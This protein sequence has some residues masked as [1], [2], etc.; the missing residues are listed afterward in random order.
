[1]RTKEEEWLLREKYFGVVSDAYLADVERL[2]NGEP[3]D[4]VIGFSLFL[5]SQ[6]D[7]SERTLIPRT[8]TEYWVEKAI[9]DIRTRFPEQESSKEPIRCLDVFSGSGCIGIAVLSHIK[10]TTMD[11]ADI[12]PRAITQIQRNI[13]QNKIDP[14]RTLVYQSDI[15][16]N[17]PKGQKYD[18][19]FA[20]PPYIA[21]KD[22]DRVDD[23]VHDFEPHTALYSA[24]NGFDHIVR[25]LDSVPQFLAPNGVVFLEFDD[26]QK[27]RLEQ[28]LLERGII[29]SMFHKD[30]FGFWRW[31]EWKY[32]L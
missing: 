28:L 8:E 3:V 27:V 18:C 21:E 16:L 23:S 11:F 24:A 6:V 17:I 13:Q 15:F 29:S 30:Q 1:M 32:Y 20:N 14:L 22:R 4:Y 12:D 10:N 25:F 19:I 9:Q 26:I 2:K 7:L 31:V 5:G